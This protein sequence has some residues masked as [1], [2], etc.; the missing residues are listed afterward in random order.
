M[1]MLNAQN[2]DAAA[3]PNHNSN[4]TQILTLI[5]TVPTGLTS[6]DKGSQ[7]FTAFFDIHIR[8]HLWIHT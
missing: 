3:D 1:Q 8:H 7:Y 2:V 5:L 6:V 4:P